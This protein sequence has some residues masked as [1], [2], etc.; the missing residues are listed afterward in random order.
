MNDLDVMIHDAFAADAERAPEMPAHWAGPTTATVTAID[1]RR[2]GRAIGTAAVGIAAA[3]VLVV[4]LAVVARDGDVDVDP[5]TMPP[6]PPAWSPP[7]T[8]FPIVDL[9]PATE[10]PGGPVVAALTRVVGV[11]GHPDQIVAPSLTYSGGASAE[12][13][14]CTWEN[15]SGG[16]RPEWNPATWSTGVTSSV[17]NGDGEFDLFMIEGLPAGAAYVGYADG[18]VQHWQRPVLGFGAFP[19][20][21]G[22][23]E[24]VTAWDASG[25]ELAVYDQAAYL[26]VAQTA[27]HPLRADLPQS[28]F[29]AVFDLTRASMRSCL[30][31]A[32]GTVSSGDIATFPEGVDQVAT[33]DECV[34]AVKDV[35]S[36]AVADLDPQFF[37]PVVSQAENPTTPFGSGE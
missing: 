32:G 30:I 19:D 24:V 23:N 15:T 2:R 33:W 3:T 14:Q 28:E 29:D 35:V 26:R 4:G 11:D 21:P 18:D 10:S 17:D 16:C 27:V 6:P 8:E 31:D 22:G 7:G 9:G 5:V 37:D 25:S 1:P 13:Q 12:L 20:V 34:V 36:Q